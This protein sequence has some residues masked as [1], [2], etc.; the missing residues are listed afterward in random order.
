MPVVRVNTTARITARPA[1]VT[2]SRGC[3]RRRS[4]AA[5][6]LDPGIAPGDRDRVRPGSRT[7]ET[8]PEDVDEV[9]DVAAHQLQAAVAII[10]PPNG[11]LSDGIGGLSGEIQNLHVEHITVDALTLEDGE[12]R[13]TTKE[14]EAA[15]R[16]RNVSQTDERVHEEAEGLRSEAPIQPL[17][18]LDERRLQP[19]RPDHDRDTAREV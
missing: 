13:I 12:R 15:L 19:A 11:D 6:M 1:D 5:R 7:P 17:R 2:S 9:P 18:A 16:I 4:N 8:N 3:A 10:P 14:L